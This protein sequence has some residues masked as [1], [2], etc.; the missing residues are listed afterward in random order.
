M[1]KKKQWEKVGGGSYGI[2][3]PKKQ[4]DWGEIFGGIFIVFVVLA[5]LST[6]S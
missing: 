1:S 3:K 2:Y 4:T 5:L 6:C